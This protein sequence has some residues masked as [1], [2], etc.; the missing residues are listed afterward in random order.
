MLT[1]CS[2]LWREGKPRSHAQEEPFV[3]GELDFCWHQCKR[4]S[5]CLNLQIINSTS[6]TMPDTQD[7]LH[8]ALL[9]F[10][11]RDSHFLW[12]QRTDVSQKL[13]KADKC[14]V[15]I[16]RSRKWKK[17][18]GSA[19]CGGWMWSLSLPSW[20]ANPL[21]L[22]QSMLH[23]RFEFLLSPLSYLRLSS[24]LVILPPTPPR[25]R[26]HLGSLS[27]EPAQDFE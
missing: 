26:T 27:K 24:L 20:G 4:C 5:E 6:I 25:R 16:E 7:T 18:V 23:M 11:L 1:E 10:P 3:I 21:G 17:Q 13:M 2:E 14:K 12:Q 19:L 8:V 22:G 15:C 9:V